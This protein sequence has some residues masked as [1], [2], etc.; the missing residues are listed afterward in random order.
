GKIA[1]IPFNVDIDILGKQTISEISE[2]AISISREDW[3]NFETSWDF[4]THPL[5]RYK[6]DLIQ[7]A[8]ENW[9]QE[10]ESAF[11]QL[12]QLEE[13]NNRYWIAAYG[14]QDELTPEV[15]DAQITI[16]R[17]DLTRDI[18]SLLSYAV[19]CIMG[20]YALESEG[21]RSPLT[22]LKKGGKDDL[23]VSI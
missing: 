3:D 19:G 7:Q 2:K 22:P 18:K 16:R 10:T 1:N 13:E 4:K 8:F 21:L 20:R 17:A 23:Q 6:T 15:P 9:Q 14:L 11:Q 5:T 12:K